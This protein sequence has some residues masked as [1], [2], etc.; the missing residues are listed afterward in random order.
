MTHGSA[1]ELVEIL[2]GCGRRGS[3]RRCRGEVT[4]GAL[5]VP[6][7]V[8][9]RRP[10]HR[11][12]RLAPPP[13]PANAVPAIRPNVR[14][15]TR[16]PRAWPPRCA[17]RGSRTWERAARQPPIPCH[18]NRT[19][20]RT[21]GN[22]ANWAESPSSPV[23]LRPRLTPSLPLS[24]P[25]DAG[26]HRWPVAG[27]RSRSLIAPMTAGAQSGIQG[28][29]GVCRDGTQGSAFFLLQRR[30]SAFSPIVGRCGGA[31]LLHA[32]RAIT[33]A[34]SSGAGGPAR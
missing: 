29:Q 18:S 24:K 1:I 12:H 22:P 34:R 3:A 20:D 32:T 13:L 8:D 19:S 7:A 27:V 5:M 28:G 15:V 17:S 2:N 25:A 33:G 14:A 4:T 30:N 21:S 11:R 10:G 31:P 26:R 23:A 16:L 6:S 9:R